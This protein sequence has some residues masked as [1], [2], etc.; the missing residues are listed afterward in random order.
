MN[1]L[2]SL[3]GGIDPSELNAKLE[4]WDPMKILQSLDIPEDNANQILHGDMSSLLKKKP[5]ILDFNLIYN[6]FKQSLNVNL[7]K[8]F[9]KVAKNKATFT[10][11]EMNAYYEAYKFWFDIVFKIG[12]KMIFKTPER[13]DKNLYITLD[14]E[15]YQMVIDEDIY[16]IIHLGNNPSIL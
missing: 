5:D 16:L 6:R 10:E 3:L 12:A 9:Y 2:Q 14:G 8:Y 4:G 1:N 7:L 11:D 13:N 15:F